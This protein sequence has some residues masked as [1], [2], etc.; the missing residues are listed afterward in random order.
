MKEKIG[1]LYAEKWQQRWSEATTGA[2]S[3]R[4]QPRLN[5]KAL[6]RLTRMSRAQ[7]SLV[8]QLRTGKIGFRAF[9]HK[10][11]V[12]GFDDPLCK[13]CEEGKEMTVEHVLMECP[14]WTTLREECFARAFKR[15]ISPT[16][17]GLLDTR[18]GCLAAAKMVGKT[19]LLVQFN[20]CDLDIVGEEENEK[21]NEEG[22]TEENA[23]EDDN[24]PAC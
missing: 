22:G 3:R 21:E 14:K 13:E 24:A 1:T 9:L 8:V 17:E 15:G 19:K 11:R 12:P 18:K 5:E 4:L 20:S 23:E 16:L 6:K 2:H 7:S 10:M